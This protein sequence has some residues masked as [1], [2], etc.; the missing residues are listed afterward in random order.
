LAMRVGSVTGHSPRAFGSGRLPSTSRSGK[1]DPAAIE[2]SDRYPQLYRPPTTLTTPVR[3]IAET[4]SQQ[5]RHPHRRYRRPP[6]HELSAE[7]PGVQMSG[8]TFPAREEPQVT[9]T[10]GPDRKAV[11][12][13]R[14]SIPPLS[15]RHFP[16]SHTPTPSVDPGLAETDRRA[17][18]GHRRAPRLRQRLTYYHD[19]TICIEP[20]D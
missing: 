3:R 15:G 14:P 18:R 9:P 20:I 17:T 1:T 12:G 5:L 10:A 19:T 6:Q 8:N 2:V 11:P 16:A 4:Y 7:M 13:Q